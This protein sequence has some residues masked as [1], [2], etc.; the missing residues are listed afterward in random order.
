MKGMIDG[1]WIKQAW[2][3]N[4]L[5]PLLRGEPPYDYEADADDQARFTRLR[6]ISDFLRCR[7]A[8]HRQPR[9]VAA[10]A[11]LDAASESWPRAAAIFLRRL[12]PESA[13]GG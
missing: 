11:D 3:S 12:F 9:L 2:D 6:Q 1:R 5:G 8:T 7:P 13:S 4:Q 10:L